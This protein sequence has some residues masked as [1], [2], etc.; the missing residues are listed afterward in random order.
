M[1]RLDLDPPLTNEIKFSSIAAVSL[2]RHR[3]AATMVKLTERRKLGKSSVYLPPFG[4]GCAPIGEIFD[5]ISDEEAAHTF[6]TA[7][8]CGVRYFDV[9]PSCTSPPSKRTSLLLH[10]IERMSECRWRRAG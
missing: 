8:S 10:S 7:L 3:S 6:E 2:E 5:R 1:Y 9:A 4:I